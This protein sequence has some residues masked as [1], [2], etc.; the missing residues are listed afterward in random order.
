MSDRP[1]SVI[2]SDQVARVVPEQGSKFIDEE[3]V[4]NSRK[5]K[6]KRKK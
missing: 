2:T 4:K 1:G 3:Q 5:R 6:R